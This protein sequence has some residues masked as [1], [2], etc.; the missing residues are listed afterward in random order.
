MYVY[1]D[2]YYKHVYVLYIYVETEFLLNYLNVL[3]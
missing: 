1:I 2:R 3:I